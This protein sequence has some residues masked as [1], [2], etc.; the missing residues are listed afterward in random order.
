MPVSEGKRDSHT[1]AA[2]S[3][4]RPLIGRQREMQALAGH[5]REKS[6]LHIYG[7]EGAGKSALFEWTQAHWREIGGPLELI[8]SRSSRTLRGTLLN[9]CDVLL[10]H[11]GC[12]AS[13]DKFGKVTK[14]GRFDDVRGLNI[15]ALKKMAHDYIARGNF[16]V[17]L[18]HLE[19]VTPMMHAFLVPLYER[20]LVLTAS[21]QSW[22]LTD[23]AFKGKLAYHCLYLLPK[24]RIDNLKRIDALALMEK[25]CGSHDMPSP[26]G[27]HIC[28]EIL[29]ISGGNPKIITEILEKAGR[30]EYHVNNR[31]NLKLIMIDCKMEKIRW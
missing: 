6:H 11:F 24:L 12:L 28:E 1:E 5:I 27:P 31:L 26:L 21:R 15:R 25:L 19:Y 2:L 14:I 3:C 8:Y 9:I 16:C 7:P 20:A 17:L 23:Y 4:A 22:E 29:N 18:D 10:K 30:P 13:V